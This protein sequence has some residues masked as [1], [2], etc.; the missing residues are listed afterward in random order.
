M[1]ECDFALRGDLVRGDFAFEEIRE[2][3]DISQ[4][5][6]GEG[7]ARAIGRAVNLPQL[8]G[9]RFYLQHRSVGELDGISNLRCPASR[10]NRVRIYQQKLS[11]RFAHW[12][13]IITA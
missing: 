1:V 13:Y 2:F 8:H 4:F 3:L 5:H 7:I 6:E 9:Q 11:M 12:L 10:G